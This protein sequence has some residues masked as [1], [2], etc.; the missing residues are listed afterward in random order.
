M[1]DLTL[2]G[3]TLT[4]SS[5]EIAHLVEKQHKDVIRDIRVMQRALLEDGADL[6]HLQEEKDNRGYTSAFHL[7]KDLTETLVTGYSI[8]LRHKVIRRLHELERR[9]APSL[10][11]AP[12]QSFAA[13][14]RLAADQAELLERQQAELAEAAPKVEALD[15]IAGSRG[16]MC[17]TDAAKHLQVPPRRLFDWLKE[18][19]WIFQRPGSSRWVGYQPRIQSGFILHK[20]TT[21]GA[22]EQGELR[23]ATQVRITP[24]GLAK[25]ALLVGE[26][27]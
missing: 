6:R 13:A 19:R 14:L 9:S 18:H 5:R 7:D 10:P 8:P 16:A 22:D 11:V 26:S 25:L 4:M 24:K 15:R 1:N 20:I 12:P 3:N 17:I 27:L 23:A 2:T 21:I